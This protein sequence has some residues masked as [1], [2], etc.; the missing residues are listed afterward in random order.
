MH[1]EVSID[2]TSEEHHLMLSLQSCYVMTVMFAGG[3]EPCW[4]L[5]AA[6]EEVSGENPTNGS[7]PAW[8]GD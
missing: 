3:P 5:V 4:L 8:D 6:T 1:R 7:G 2:N